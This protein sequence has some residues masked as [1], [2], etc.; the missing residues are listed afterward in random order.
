MLIMTCCHIAACLIGSQPCLTWDLA[1]CATMWE[2]LSIVFVNTDGNCMGFCQSDC[3]RRLHNDCSACDDALQI[4]SL[5]FNAARSA[6][7]DLG[8][9]TCLIKANFQ[10]NSRPGSNLSTKAT[11][12]LNVLNYLRSGSFVTFSHH[13]KKSVVSPQSC[14]RLLLC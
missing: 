5:S 8:T 11:V 7:P 1:L 6:W 10:V 14:L 12:L 4:R 13:H 2:L 9:S 3:L